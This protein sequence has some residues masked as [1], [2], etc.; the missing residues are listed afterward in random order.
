MAVHTSTLFFFL[1]VVYQLQTPSS[2]L[3]ELISSKLSGSKAFKQLLT[4]IFFVPILLCIVLLFAISNKLINYDFGIILYTVVL[5]TLGVGYLTIVSNNINQFHKSDITLRNDLLKTN[6]LLN[7]Y[8]LAID[9]VS[10][11]AITDQKGEIISVNDN[12]CSISQYSKEEL[13]GNNH[14]IINSGYHSKAFFRDLWET[15]SQGKEWVGE[16]KNKAK[17]GSYYWVHTVIVPVMMDGKPM[18]YVSIRRDITRH[19]EIDA[20]NAQKIERLEFKNKELEQFTY[21]ASHDLQEPLRT[22]RSFAN[23]LRLDHSSQL[24]SDAN[25]CIQFISE[26]STRMS[27]LVK[28]LL[29]YSRLGIEPRIDRV[30]VKQ[31]LTDLRADMSLVFQESGANLS[32]DELPEVI[33]LE[34]ELRA[35]F[36]NL[37]GN[38]I[39][40]SRQGIVPEIKISSFSDHDFW[41]FV[42]EDNGIGIDKNY[43]DKIFLLFQRLHKKHEYSGDGIGLAY[44][45]KIVDLHGGI[46]WVESTVGQGSTFHFTLLKTPNYNY[47]KA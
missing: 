13:I 31:L 2:T 21:I 46:I 23:I 11:V 27:S 37:I 25:E 24:D 12:F 19:K 8:K 36:Q 20:F 22:L 43:R 40:F 45:S 4:P 44:C 28:G 18:Q 17:D 42:V 26:A 29:D 1:Y 39:K 5:I 6:E 47:E 16:I 3:S 7:R 32:F 15:I 10:I 34:N 35:L 41:H 9:Q 38:S 14:R 33:G 30:N